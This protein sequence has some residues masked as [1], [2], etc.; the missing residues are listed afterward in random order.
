MGAQPVIMLGM[1]A[2]KAGTS[3][4]HSYLS[5]HPECHFRSIKELHYFDALEN[6][7]IDRELAAHRSQADAIR[8]RIA[9]GRAKPQAAVRLKDREDWIGVLEGEESPSAYLGYLTGDVGDARVAGEVTPAY[10]LLP[11]AR[12]E[13]M[14]RMAADVR[15]V[16]LMRDP[17][18]RLWS[19]VRMIA[20][21][22][23]GAG[24]VEPGRAGR[25]LKR[26]MRGDEPQIATRGD[27]ASALTKFAATIDP[28][29]LCVLLFEDLVT[30][31][32]V[33]RLCRFLGLTPR[34]PDLAPVHEGQALSMTADQRRAARDWLAP[35]YDFVADW[36]GHRPAGWA[37]DLGEVR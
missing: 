8:A 15:F 6:G 24:R 25:I 31:R 3:W 2:T 18:A 35:Q 16:Y 1:G 30:G 33:D 22:R 21:R 17:V 27:Y 10:A 32:A 5:G 19:H 13:T 23:D 7:R 12:L 11:V 29:R 14:A 9:T 36:M 34:S 20:G 4:M 28:A 37:Y 26:V